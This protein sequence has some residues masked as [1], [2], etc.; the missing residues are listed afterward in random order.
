MIVTAYIRQRT[1]G[2]RDQPVCDSDHVQVEAAGYEEA[3][4]LVRLQLPLS[5]LVGSWRVER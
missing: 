3:R 2:V 4:E 5:M 1:T